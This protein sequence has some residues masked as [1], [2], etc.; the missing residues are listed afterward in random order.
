MLRTARSL[1][2]VG[3][4]TLGFDLAR[5]QTKPP[6]CYWASWQLPRPDFTCTALRSMQSR[7]HRLAT[8]S[9]CVGSVHSMLTSNTLGALLSSGV[10]CRVLPRPQ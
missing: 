8:A 1:P 4:S 10:N 2:P 5:F 3:L 6:A 7:C 9:L